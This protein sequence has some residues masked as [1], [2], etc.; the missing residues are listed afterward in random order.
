[1]ISGEELA[2][3][4]AGDAD[5]ALVARIES[6]LPEDRSLADRL[7]AIL[8]VDAQLAAWEAPDL[9]PGAADRLMAAVDADL[10]RLAD[11]ASA[12]ASDAVA[13]GM[14]EPSSTAAGG[15]GGVEAAG[16]RPVVASGW[17]RLRD[18]WA[19]VV[20]GLAM[21]QLAGAAAALVL[22]IGVGAVVAGGLGGSD[23]AS[24]AE[25]MDDLAAAEPAPEMADAGG[26]SQGTQP[27]PESEA[28]S[29]MAADTG[30]ES[31]TAAAS[32]PTSEGPDSASGSS[33]GSLPPVI[34]D[35]RVVADLADI[36]PTALRERLEPLVALITPEEGAGG[37]SVDQEA[38]PSPRSFA[39]TP[40]L[41]L[42]D[43]R[44]GDQDRNV[45]AACLP[46]SPD[47]VIVAEVV[48][49]APEGDAP[50][51][52]VILYVQRGQVV[53]V[54]VDGCR[55]LGVRED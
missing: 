47:E 16:G 10:A 7:A 30:S 1:M 4:A 24:T 36:D 21:P 31:A 45:V 3:Y 39:S 15:P 43:G 20:D 41:A 13:D 51:R 12:G 52:D 46:D 18:R 34:D 44:V 42:A 9:E 5:P 6:A 28:M 53:V 19:T 37:D 49:L 38:S 48:V 17:R 40:E 32:A 50:E 27:A 26:G 2:A 25:M 35:A 23:D 54:A 11:P 29:E 22:V 33:A 55:R 14:T 8:E